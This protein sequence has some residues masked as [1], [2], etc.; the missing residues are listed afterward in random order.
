VT[1]YAAPAQTKADESSAAHMLTK[2]DQARQAI[3]RDN[4]DDALQDVNDAREAAGKIQAKV[5]SINAE[6]EQV[7]LAASKRPQSGAADRPVTT[8]E[9]TGYTTVS[10]DM[11]IAKTHL[12][13]AKTALQSGTMTDADK[14]LAAVQNG[15]TLANVA[16]D[17]PLLKA[18]QDLSAAKLMAQ[19]NR[20]GDAT[21]LLHSASSH[22]REYSYTPSASRADKAKNLQQEIDSNISTLGQ[23]PSAAAKKIDRWWSEIVD[24]SKADQPWR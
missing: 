20:L 18:S 5:V 9:A 2:I 23:D 10:I 13:A 11:E 3:A 16:S 12:N 14:E 19:Q 6:R 8:P 21:A 4:K 17:S 22:L 15:V 24:L 1:G 7:S